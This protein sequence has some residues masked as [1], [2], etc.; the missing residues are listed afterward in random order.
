MK[1]LLLVAA[2]AAVAVSAYGQGKL[3]LANNDNQ[4]IYFGTSLASGDMGK[5][6]AGNPLAG[7]TLWSG[8]GG[9]L[10]S[11]AG[12]P[13]LLVGLFAGATSDNLT[14]ATTTANIGALAFAGYINPQVAVELPGLPAGTP[15][16]FR[17]DV[18]DSR[19]SS[20][21]DAWSMIDRY[22]GSTGVF[23]ATPAAAAYAP[24]YQATAPVD[25][26]MP[27]G[28]FVPVDYAG[29]PGYFGGIEVYATVPEP[30]MFALAG[31]GIASLLI[32]RRRK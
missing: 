28:T 31:L 30:S 4:L 27:V 24:I 6:V 25:S 21:A 8:A 7:Q 14:L 13:T 16:F 19:N 26:T 2:A 1:K 20:A 23:Q 11:L 5:T 3:A 29:F 9:T 12:S 17:I 32:F 18:Y 15:A 22:G 10:S